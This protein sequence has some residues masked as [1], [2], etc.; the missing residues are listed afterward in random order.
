MSSP[1]HERARREYTPHHERA[2]REYTPH[3]ERRDVSTTAHPELLFWS[4]GT[5]SQVLLEGHHERPLHGSVE[6]I[7]RSKNC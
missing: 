2:R 3:Y 1:H 6:D 4:K 5:L 7:Y